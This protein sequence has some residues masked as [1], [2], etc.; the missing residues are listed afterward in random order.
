MYSVF[1]APPLSTVSGCQE[2]QQK[3]RGQHDGMEPICYLPSTIFASGNAK[4]TVPIRKVLTQINVKN[5]R[6]LPNYNACVSQWPSQ[7]DW[8]LARLVD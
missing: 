7:T 3:G 5:R 4:I 8:L 2:P 1:L 6:A